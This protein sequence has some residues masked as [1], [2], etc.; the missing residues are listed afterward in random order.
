MRPASRAFFVAMWILSGCAAAPAEDVERSDQAYT[1][2]KS[3]LTRTLATPVPVPTDTPIG[4]RMDDAI[5]PRLSG[6]TALPAR[7]Y[8]SGD[9]PCTIVSWVDG[10]G[11]EALHR[12]RCTETLANGRDVRTIDIVRIG[13]RPDILF[14]PIVIAD[15]NGDGKVDSFSD[16]SGA[17]LE[18]HD[19]NY[20]GKVD[21]MV[22]AASRVPGLSLA[23]YEPGWSI[24]PPGEIANRIRE[25]EDKDGSFETESITAKMPS[26][27][28]Q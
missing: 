24:S 20:D 21:R 26:W 13:S 14:P 23:D 16:R 3:S 11:V 25:D 10:A 17:V 28:V 22:E 9:S 7:A 2:S 1:R 5:A 27:F 18:L 6:L 8:L 19:E 15:H 4:M 12:Q